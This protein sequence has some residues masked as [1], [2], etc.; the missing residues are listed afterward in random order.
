MKEDIHLK[1]LAVNRGDLLWGLAVNSVGSQTIAP[2]QAYPPS[3]H[4]S[5]YLFSVER[6]RILNEYQLLYIIRGAGVFRSAHL[7]SEVPLSA[8]S[9][10]LLYPG[11]WHNYHPDPKTGWTEYW[12]GFNGSHMENWVQNGFFRKERPVINIGLQEAVVNLY[13]DAIT[14][15]MG[16]ESAFQQRLSGMVSHLLGLALF[17][18][19]KEVFSQVGDRINR[20]KMII[21]E[22][23]RT[24]SPEELAS[25]LCM[26]YSNFR[27]VFKDYTGF[28]PAKYILEVR[29]SKVK[30]ALTNTAMPVKEIAWDMGFENYDYFFTAFRRTVGMTPVSYRAVTQGTRKR[31]KTT[32]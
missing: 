28:S 26:G 27:K 21:S 11:E 29:F 24:I 17:Y 8:G 32:G 1:Y 15:A 2:G 20:A 13:E 5:R 30:E 7:P 10:F 12:I 9:L 23:Y 18:D 3:G 14:T 16:Q 4:P 31:A 22:E 25:R 6:G 19:R